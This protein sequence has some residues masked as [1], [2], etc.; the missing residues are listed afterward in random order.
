MGSLRIPKDDW[1]NST[2]LFIFYFTAVWDSAANNKKCKGLRWCCL[3]YRW[4][5]KW[6]RLDWLIH[7]GVSKARQLP[8]RC[9]CLHCKVNS[10]DT[11]NK[12][13]WK[14]FCQECVLSRVWLD[15]A[16]PRQRL[17]HCVGFDCWPALL[18]GT[19]AVSLYWPHSVEW[20]GGAFF[21]QGS[22]RSH[23]LA[24]T[25]SLECSVLCAIKG[26]FSC[27]AVNRKSDG[28]CFVTLGAAAPSTPCL[29]LRSSCYIFTITIK[30]VSSLS[31]CI[32]L[33]LLLHLWWPKQ[34][35]LLN[36]E[37]FMKSQIPPF[38]GCHACENKQVHYHTRHQRETENSQFYSRMSTLVWW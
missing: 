1:P 17:L 33:E 15:S 2:G 32:H 24:W 20:G 9:A 35:L 16:V 4:D 31:V 22:S 23:G 26:V 18:I 37:T 14:M 29:L 36:H 34:H 21:S 7:E 27:F 11:V 38:P 3:R 12:Y 25:T 10:A 30:A 6:I 8:R 13:G 19:P 28:L 5:M